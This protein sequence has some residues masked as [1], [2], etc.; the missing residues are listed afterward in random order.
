[1][2][3][4]A[5]QNYYTAYRSYP[6]AYLADSDGKPAQSAARVLILPFFRQPELQR[7]YDQ[8]NFDE[9]WNGPNNSQL[10]D[11]VATP[12]PCP[13]DPNV[14]TQTDYVAVVGPQTVWPGAASR[15]P[16]DIN[17]SIGDSL[18]LLEVGKSGIHWMEPRDLSFEQARKGFARSPGDIGIEANDIHRIT[19]GL[20][21]APHH[22]LADDTPAEVLAALLTINGGE[23]VTIPAAPSTGN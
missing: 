23:P 2:I 13:V 3:G 22:F 9:P 21:A 4:V 12:Y 11:A 5:I 20:S 16:F 6:P 15:G 7:L 10:A 8:Y 17:D 18:M 1:M 19:V 14:R